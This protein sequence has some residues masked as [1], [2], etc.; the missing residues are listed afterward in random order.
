MNI[1]VSAFTVSEKFYNTLTV[2]AELP[3]RGPRSKKKKRIPGKKFRF[4]DR[5]YLFFTWFCGFDH[6]KR[7]H[8]NS[9]CVLSAV[10]SCL[11]KR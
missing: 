1:K 7:D 6:V 9:L 8:S 5:K 11:T 4:K 3:L 2:E 10:F